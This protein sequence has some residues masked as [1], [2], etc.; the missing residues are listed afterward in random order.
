MSGWGENAGSSDYL[1][2][3]DGLR[4]VSIAL[5]LAFHF[6]I[7][8]VSGGYIGVDVFFVI[9]GFLIIRLIVT[10]LEQKKFS[11]F[12]FWGRRIRRLMPAIAVTLLLSLAVGFLVM[13]P[14]DYRALGLNALLAA[15][16][17]INFS[18]IG[19]TDYFDESVVQNPLVHFWS[20]AVEEQFYFV[21]P[22]LALALFAMFGAQRGR[23]ATIV[24]LIVL[25]VAAFVGGEM[26]LR[27]GQANAAYYLMPTRFG[28]LA[29][30][31]VLALWMHA[32]D[33]SDRLE[34]APR[35]A[36]DIATLAGL[37]AV[38]W[39]ALTYT[40][41]TPFPGIAAL[42]VTFGAL[43]LLAFAGRGYLKP[44]LTNWPVAYLGR[45]S[46]SLYLLHWPAY[47]FA[48]YYLSRPLTPIETGVLTAVV[49]VA[50]AALHHAVENPVRFSKLFARG[51][52][53]WFVAPSMAAAIAAAAVVFTGAGLPE[54]I[55]VARRELA[56]DAGQFH[57]NHFG[58]ADYAANRVLTLGAEGAAPEFILIGDSKAHQF[59]LGIDR[60]LRERNRAATF[61]AD[62]GC[63]YFSGTA[64]VYNGR[65]DRGCLE[66][67]QQA[68]ELARDSDLPLIIAIGWRGYIPI[69]VSLAG[70][71]LRIT[72]AEYAQM[73]ADML[74][75]LADANPRRQRIYIVGSNTGF[76]SALPIASCLV[77]PDF[78][79]LPCAAQ[80]A[81]PAESYVRS[82][83][84][85]R[86]I[87][88]I[89]S[90]QRFVYLPMQ[91]VFCPRGLCSQVGADG[92]VLFS[93]PDHLSKD[94]SMVLAP[95][96]LALT[97]FN[98]ACSAG[99]TT[100]ELDALPMPP[101]VDVGPAHKSPRETPPPPR[102]AAAPAARAPVGPAQPF[103]FDLRGEGAVAQLTAPAPLRAARSPG[104]VTMS[105]YVAGAA[106]GG[107]TGGVS[108]RVAPP[109]EDY[110]SGRTIEVRIRARG[111]AGA[112]KFS[113]TY[114][115]SDVGNSGW[116]TLTVTNEFRDTQFTYQV[117]TMVRG[118]DDFL[119]IMPPESGS[120][121][122]E[123]IEI[124]V[125]D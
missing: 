114:S 65:L 25:G 30:G 119:G 55:P 81:F 118:G 107:H 49:L 9:S 112:T 97:G 53:F 125:V 58:G 106:P 26:L 45:I 52:M 61:Y 63:S 36:A 38:L 13:A 40:A 69:M 39:C 17:V 54:R 102:R 72:P 85:Q 19:Q 98:P 100:E 4:A 7:G 92:R 11:L 5:V 44:L 24:S 27:M 47:A 94:G 31:G 89:Q 86:M 8:G 3:I 43:A 23:M 116:R 59:T 79:G 111:V 82:E 117:G 64:L 123:R 83:T 66:S 33:G 18:L 2:H 80:S 95:R 56:V 15:G 121:E 73:S 37:G 113:A 50:S 62:P 71:P 70:E 68:L 67:A 14:G 103:Q 41:A 77:R 42:P 51:R 96:L 88:L 93:D 1:R 57:R 109:F 28:Q 12:G 115:T 104:G 29:F 32:R 60:F 108:V 6:G 46:Y 20:L 124:V 74:R 35:W 101:P 90:D 76:N 122:I 78:L 48:V 21:F 84:E 110:F 22:F 34:K 91:D 16:S 120:V 87:E 10:G 75:A 105:G 99:C